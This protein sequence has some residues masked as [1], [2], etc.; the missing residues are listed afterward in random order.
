MSKIE[1]AI[2]K[3]LAFFDIFSRPLTLEE[4]WHFLHQFKTSKYQVLIGLRKL[5][6]KGKILEKNDYFS[7]NF[8]R[9]IFRGYIR[10][11]KICQKNFQKARRYLGLLKILPF[12]KNISV[13]NSLAFQSSD[14]KS[15]IDILLVTKKNRLWF[16]RALVV[17]VL[18]IL[19]QN[20]NKWY[21]AGKFCL[22]FAFDE[23][24]LN[25]KKFRLKNDIYFSYWLAMLAPVL[26]RGLYPRFIQKNAW[27]YDNLPN[28][29]PEKNRLHAGNS[30]TEKI[31]RG[32]LGDKLEK[33]LGTW[34]MKRIWQ[35]PDMLR[36]GGSVVADIHMLKIPGDKRAEYQGQW[37]ERLK[38]LRISQSRAKSRG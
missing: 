31:F 14:E 22:G 12:V 28:W 26:D 7:L 6:K 24:V 38:R 2:L 36:P 23:E 15:D 8:N 34:Q 17:L 27:I 9:Q 30:W 32:A 29:Q 33:L 20:K 35:D 3:T 1:K 19:G 37:Q 5:A 4:L 21:R 11:R 18:E 25:L 16:T 13:I 10:R